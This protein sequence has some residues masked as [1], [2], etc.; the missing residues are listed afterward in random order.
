[1]PLSFYVSF[2]YSS[3]NATDNNTIPNGQE[4]IG[5]GIF[6]KRVFLSVER[7]IGIHEKW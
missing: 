5:I 1:V 3:A 4:E 6:E 2:I 7:Q